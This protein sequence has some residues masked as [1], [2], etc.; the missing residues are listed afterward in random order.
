MNQDITCSVGSLGTCAR[1][2]TGSIPFDKVVRL[3]RGLG[4]MG[5][6]PRARVPMFMVLGPLKDHHG[7]R[8]KLNPQGAVS[9]EWIFGSRYQTYIN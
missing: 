7:Q 9:E 6:R 8:A 1:G 3:G 2:E 5:S 4:T